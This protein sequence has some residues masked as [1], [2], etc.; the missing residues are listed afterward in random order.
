[1]GGDT[2]PDPVNSTTPMGLKVTN[3]REN[4]MEQ[5]I[6]FSDLPPGRDPLVKPVD[7]FSLYAVYCSLHQPKGYIKKPTMY[8]YLHRQPLWIVEC[9]PNYEQHKIRIVWN[10]A[11]RGVLPNGRDNLK[12]DM[13]VSISDVGTDPAGL[14]GTVG[15]YSAQTAAI[16][17]CN[18]TQPVDGPFKYIVDGVRR[19]PKGKPHRRHQWAR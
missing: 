8:S 1:M 13:S 14:M 7:H 16:P 3:K 11:W 2:F 5:T 18:K 17:G 15:D 19:K 9:R 6:T 12:V 4:G 10:A